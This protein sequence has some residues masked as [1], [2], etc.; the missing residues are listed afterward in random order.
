MSQNKCPNCNKFKKPW[1]ELCWECTEKE[2]KKPTCDICG[3][4]VPEGHNL[5]KKHWLEKQ[6]ASKKIK[7]AEFIKEK[8]SENFKEK[9]EGKFNSPYGKVKSKSE[10][11]LTYFFYSN[12]LS[13]VLYEKSLFLEKEYKPDFTIEDEKGNV[14]IFEHFSEMDEKYIEKMKQKINSY[15]N[16]CKKNKECYF[17]YSLEKD[18]NN[19]SDNI[20]RLFNEKTPIKKAI[21]K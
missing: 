8:I 20:G 14:I 19:L 15:E 12:G 4:K 13:K 11:L 2:N 16:F 1:F 17:I 9:F 10:L 3:T 6:E 21:W 7:K 5:C 18:L